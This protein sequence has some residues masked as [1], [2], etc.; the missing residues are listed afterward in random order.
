MP[1]KAAASKTIFLQRSSFSPASLTVSRGTAL[2]FTWATKMPH[3]VYGAGIAIPNRTSGT[4][5]RTATRSGTLVCTLHPGMKL[6]L[7]VR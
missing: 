3:N 2:R 4:V 5:T 1:A 6:K 7:K